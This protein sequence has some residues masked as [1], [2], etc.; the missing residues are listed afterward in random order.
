MASWR[1]DQTVVLFAWVDHCIQAQL[2]FDSTIQQVLMD[3][4]KQLGRTNVQL[5][6]KTRIYDKLHN[7]SKTSAVPRGSKKFPRPPE[8]KKRGSTCLPGMTQDLRDKVKKATR[9]FK[10]D[11]RKRL[12]TSKITPQL[13]RREDTHLEKARHGDTAN[14]LSS[15]PQQIEQSNYNGRGDGEYREEDVR[16]SSQR[17]GARGFSPYNQIT[18]L[19]NNPSY[20]YLQEK[21]LW[22]AEEGR[23]EVNSL[24]RS[25][26]LAFE[27]RAEQIEKSLGI[28]QQKW[29]EIISPLRNLCSR[30]LRQN[31]EEVQRLKAFHGLE[32][33]QVIR[34]RV[35]LRQ[36]NNRLTVQNRHLENAQE[37]RKAAADHD[38]LESDLFLHSRMISA[39]RLTNATLIKDTPFVRDVVLDQQRFL[40]Q[41]A[42]EAMLQIQSELESLVHVY[43]YQGASPTSIDPCSKL[44]IFLRSTPRCQAH[45]I[46]MEDGMDS[47][48]W[49]QGSNM[50]L[51]LGN[52]VLTAVR[53]H[54]FYTDFPASGRKDF[55]WS[56]LQEHRKIQMDFGG[57][58]QLS[59][60]DQLAYKRIIE[61]E[62][63]DEI[64]SREATKHANGLIEILAPLFGLNLSLHDRLEDRSPYTPDN[65]SKD[66]HFR[67]FEI[68]RVALKFK[69]LSVITKQRYEFTVHGLRCSDEE[70]PVRTSPDHSQS[71]QDRPIPSTGPFP[72]ASLAIYEAG[73]RNH[74]NP[75]SDAL[76]KT[77]N[78]VEFGEKRPQFLYTTHIVV[79][80]SD[81]SLGPCS[82]SNSRGKNSMGEGACRSGADRVIRHFIEFEVDGTESA[83]ASERN[84][85]TSAGSVSSPGGSLIDV[86]KSQ[87][88]MNKLSN[89]VNQVT[90]PTCSKVLYNDYSLLRHIKNNSCLICSCQQK[91]NCKRSLQKHQR[92]HNHEEVNAAKGSQLT[93]AVDIQAGA[94]SQTSSSDIQS[95]EN[96]PGQFKCARCGL[97]RDTKKDLRHHEESN[98]C[99]Q[100]EDCHLW[101]QSEPE[102]V[103]HWK[104]N[105]GP[106]NAIMDRKASVASAPTVGLPEQ[107]QVDNLTISLKPLTPDLEPIVVEDS[108][109]A[110]VIQDTP[111]SS[112]EP[113]TALP[114]V[115]SSPGM[116][117][118]SS[119]PEIFSS[120]NEHRSPPKRAHESEGPA[121]VDGS[122][123]EETSKRQRR[124]IESMEIATV[125]Q[126]ADSSHFRRRL[127]GLLGRESHVG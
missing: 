68:F 37:K 23:L 53:N 82:Y 61:S 73:P 112:I 56:L 16:P 71:G 46:P 7:F 12:R 117:V 67:L 39:L 65:L 60:L 21:T 120:Q 49:L 27:E 51:L 118:T 126:Q 36:E 52:L 10:A 111:R 28:G 15:R 124:G 1:E 62:D 78:F 55:W 31:Q 26:E 41:E 2:D 29:N 109:R 35:Q 48:V 57:W 99:S 4:D 123:G 44:G 25:W 127:F 125:T 96:V 79:E 80:K 3:H 110:M 38:P 100:C 81:Q 18:H 121:I 54:V 116:T 50:Q 13:P 22:T 94:V 98:A 72:L 11:S 59:A 63:H 33:T 88:S 84:R 42:V 14:I 34:E 47:I 32:M 102:Y 75:F 17:A 19:A 5:F 108:V 89:G 70:S 85:I 8:I 95:H 43:Q 107:P 58:R 87:A 83:E 45:S 64:V 115:R 74:I 113:A 122:T 24:M 9:D 20:T 103:E 119:L 114:D 92:E 104:N 66:I 91:F 86:T 93:D 105:H 69:S 30:T 76:V 101:F 40:S 77:G 6:E 97:S 90:C 106:S